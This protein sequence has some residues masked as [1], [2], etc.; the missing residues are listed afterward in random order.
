[1][2]DGVTV[3]PI[4]ERLSALV[5]KLVL[6]ISEHVESCWSIDNSALKYRLEGITQFVDAISSTIVYEVIQT[7]M[8]KEALKNNFENR[9]YWQGLPLRKLRTGD[10]Y[11]SQFTS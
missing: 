8:A 7:L 10:K 9:K 1:M 11:V 4:D 5:D 6:E 3:G 2:K